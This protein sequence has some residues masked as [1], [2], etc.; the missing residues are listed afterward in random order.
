M[1]QAE[2]K[3]HQAAHQEQL[4][5]IER[6]LQQMQSERRASRQR[7]R[8]LAPVVQPSLEE[9][10]G[11]L[12]QRL[13]AMQS[14]AERT[15]AAS[16]H[17]LATVLEKLPGAPPEALAPV[18][19]D[20]ADHAIPLA[21]RP[22]RPDG[23]GPRRAALQTGSGFAPQ[24]RRLPPAGTQQGPA[25]SLMASISQDTAHN[26]ALD[27]DVRS[28]AA[29]LLPPSPIARRNDG[30][31]EQADAAAEIGGTSLA[32]RGSRRDRAAWPVGG[33]GDARA[34][35]CASG[36][37]APAATRG[38]R[39]LPVQREQSAGRHTN[40]LDVPRSAGAADGD[41]ADSV[42]RGGGEDSSSGYAPPKR[43]RKQ[44]RTAP[45]EPARAAV[46]ALRRR[47]KHAG[48]HELAPV[49][50]EQG[51]PAGGAGPPQTNPIQAAPAG[52]RQGRASPATA[53]AGS[54]P[55]AALVSQLVSPASEDLVQPAASL[56]GDAG[57]ASATSAERCKRKRSVGH[58][59][60]LDRWQ[61]SE[62]VAD[63]PA[64]AFGQGAP[65]GSPLLS[66]TPGG[67]RRRAARAL[68]D[69]PSQAN[70]TQS[71]RE[72]AYGRSRYRKAS[73]GERARPA[74][75]Q[76]A[77]DALAAIDVNQF[78]IV[79]HPIT[80]ITSKV[81]EAAKAAR[82]KAATLSWSERLAV[83]ASERCAASGCD[84][85]LPSLGSPAM[86]RDR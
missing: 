25:D 59:A 77:Q 74:I 43:S 11:W 50:P 17:A 6:Q 14:A 58:A 31:A 15:A 34:L 86:C 35:P 44:A 78:G 39:R 75:S 72:R 80:A 29:E 16:A 12:Q 76:A 57:G 8:D 37:A 41:E 73:Q 9:Q 62:A 32:E 10:R 71:T 23:E 20:D 48:N 54:L 40:E 66:G 81:L 7:A 83:K 22:P 36:D 2:R 53:A 27:Q 5:K 52:Q 33:R 21:D 79:R 64:V 49:L 3:E 55:Q 1:A 68:Q 69:K 18:R 28:L 47:R 42:S 56:A 26:T 82:P 45:A 61:E 24:L 63:S 84:L 46:T 70:A 30:K 38:A 67:D 85:L 51:P 65:H 19:R 13:D 4:G 60:R